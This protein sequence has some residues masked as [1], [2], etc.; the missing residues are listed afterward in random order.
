[1]HS[2]HHLF[3]QAQQQCFQEPPSWASCGATGMDYS[4]TDH[5]NKEN[6]G[7]SPLQRQR[8][9][10]RLVCWI[11]VAGVGY[12]ILAAHVLRGMVPDIEI[13][14]TGRKRVRRRPERGRKVGTDG[15]TVQKGPLDGIIEGHLHLIDIHVPTTRDAL[16]STRYNIQGTFCVLEWTAQQKDPT[17]V[18]LFDDLVRSSELCQVTKHTTDLYDA[19][20]AARE[21][22]LQLR[23]ATLN[24]DIWERE[25]FRH[26]PQPE[27]HAIER[28]IPPTAVVFHESRCG[29][30]LVSNLLAAFDPE[31]TKVYSEA[32]PPLKALQL[33]A[34]PT[35]K[36]HCSQHRQLVRDVFYLMG[37]TQRHMTPE[38]NIFYKLQ[39][40]AVQYV[41]LLEKSLPQPV[42]W[43]YLYRDNVPVLM[44]H[45]KGS[46]VDPKSEPTNVLGVKKTPKCLE[47]YGQSEQPTVLRELVQAQGR[48]VQSLSKEEYC[49]AH[50]AS[51]SESAIQHFSA[52]QAASKRHQKTPHFFVN[53]NQLPDVLWDH[54]LPS[55]GV[56]LKAQDIHKMER[57]GALYTQ[58]R[59]PGKNPP[60]K[61]FPGDSHHKQTDVPSAIASAA[62]TFMDHTF[63]KLEALKEQTLKEPALKEKEDED[64]DF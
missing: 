10:C 9:F 61:V 36:P 30:T 56:P 40:S 17:R 35:G 45:F 60:K 52:A 12:Q 47:A 34:C 62:S 28:S 5:F 18:P 22:D 31:T 29:S 41:E 39:S 2:T 50:L 57:V 44:S 3:Y 7:S 6:D 23:N 33:E 21:F 48:T 16:Q 11:L 49:A 8:R 46:V 24:H 15:R 63:G 64:E 1:M 37:R 26:I 43:M 20:Q 53:Y 38:H 32:A 58:G 25:Q 55:L 27:A 42:P 4:E 14:K 54:V 59:T 13:D 51:L 19:V